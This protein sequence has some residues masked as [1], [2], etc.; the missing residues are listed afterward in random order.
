MNVTAEQFRNARDELRLLIADLKSQV[1]SEAVSARQIILCSRRILD[2]WIASDGNST[3]EPIIDFL[4]IESE[5][6]YLLGGREAGRARPGRPAVESG[7]AAEAAEVESCGNFYR[8]HFKRA[9]LNLASHLR[10]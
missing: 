9:V 3:D 5:T 4:G 2:L 6:D 1:E 10:I 8:E 7:S